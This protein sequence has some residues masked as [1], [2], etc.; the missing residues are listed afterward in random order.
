MPAL[1][2]IGEIHIYRPDRFS[3]L[4][5]DSDSNN[6]QRR[7]KKRVLTLSGSRQPAV[8]TSAA[9][10]RNWPISCNV[11]P[12]LSTPREPYSTAA[13]SRVSDNLYDVTRGLEG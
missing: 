2:I 1:I 4:S 7:V 12:S 13:P 9:A 5:L 3:S 11:A 8:L 10:P 6:N